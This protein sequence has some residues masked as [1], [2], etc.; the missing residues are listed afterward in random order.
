MSAPVGIR[1]GAG[2]WLGLVRGRCLVA[3]PADASE[4]T[5]EVV[6]Q[7]LAGT[8]GMEQLLATVLSG[9]LDL[10]GLPS[11]AIVSFREGRPL[12]AIL[13]GE[14]SLHLDC[15]GGGTAE[16]LGTGVA[17]WT[18]RV[19]PDV[20]S[21][22]LVVDDAAR[23]CGDL[24]LEAGAVR[25]SALRAELVGRAEAADQPAT[26][27]ERPAVP[28]PANAEAPDEVA[29]LAGTTAPDSLAPDPGGPGTEAPEAAADD[30]TAQDTGTED[31]VGAHPVTA[32]TEPEPDPEPGPDPEP[33]ADADA[34]GDAGVEAGPGAPPVDGERTVVGPP[35]APEKPLAPEHPPVPSGPPAPPASREPAPPA[36]E[37][38]AAREL[39]D[40]VPWLAAAR[41]PVPP[42]SAPDATAAPAPERL[43]VEVPLDLA[44]TVAPGE[45]L[46]AEAADDAD[47]VLSPGAAASHRPAPPAPDHSPGPAHPP[48]PGTP[49]EPPRPGPSQGASAEDADHDG[50]TVLKSELDLGAAAA[51]QQPTAAPAPPVSTGPLVLARLCSDGHANPPTT[52]TCAVCGQSLGGEAQQVRRPSLGR[53][54]LSTGEVLELDRPA[55]IGRQPQAHR[56]GS[57]TMPRMI[58]V[59]S[60]HGDISRSHCEV[61]LDGWHVQLRD[62]KATNGT[63]LLR[64]GHAPRRLGQGESVLVLDGDIADL[65]DGISLRFEGVL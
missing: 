46:D 8:P 24:P 9:R 59:R 53:I 65:G 18:E 1:Y 4:E 26:V 14:V 29:D 33:L 56:V 30:S 20:E 19:V 42:P 48:V 6:W 34:D 25:L 12:H 64:E 17:T 44:L 58:Q 7:L 27:A 60:P 55:V 31:T 13:R 57:G 49:P 15:S 3:L 47:T 45:L 36:R 22:E 5:A 62:L 51:P 23:P 61:A 43:L 16:V 39:I 41:K 38:P 28:G 52:S 40:S 2:P 35:P 21:F 32:E 54:R 37:I 10:T 50:H 11:F 63:V